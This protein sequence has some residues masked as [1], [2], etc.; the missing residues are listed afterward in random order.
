MQAVLYVCMYV[1]SLTLLAV[2][3]LLFDLDLLQRVSLSLQIMHLSQNLWVRP[4]RLHVSQP[5]SPGITADKPK[6]G[7][8]QAG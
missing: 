1:Q 2:L 3:V 5:Q 6:E 7:H 4:T 8:S